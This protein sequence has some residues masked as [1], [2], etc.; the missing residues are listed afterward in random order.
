MR[1]P[2]HQP[3]LADL[4][5]TGENVKSLAQNFFD[6]LR[7]VRELHVH[8]I[9]GGDGI[10]ETDFDSQNTAYILY[11]FSIGTEAVGFLY[12][13]DHIAAMSAAGAV[14]HIIRNDSRVLPAMRAD[15]EG[16]FVVR[17]LGCF[18]IINE[19]ELC[20]QPEKIQGLNCHRQP[21]LRRGLRFHPHQELVLGDN[22]PLAD[23]DGGE[24]LGVHQG[25]GTGT[26]N[27]QNLRNL[28]CAE[29]DGKLVIG[30][31]FRHIFRFLSFDISYVITTG[32][33]CICGHKCEKCLLGRIPQSPGYAENLLRPRTVP[34]LFFLKGEINK[35]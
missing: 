13:V 7:T 20:F 17:R 30:G 3:G 19:A 15:S 33:Q 25:V 27:V 23:L 26:G 16:G 2:E 35:L 1:N 24:S 6:Q 21:P 28:L 31:V 5:C 9:I 10:E 11:G 18:Q 8:Q 29:R 22:H 12:I 4:R 34:A 32:K 14:P